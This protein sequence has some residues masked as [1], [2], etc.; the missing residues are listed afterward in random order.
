MER[1]HAL[2]CAFCFLTFDGF[3]ELAEHTQTAHVAPEDRIARDNVPEWAIPEEENN[4]MLPAPGTG[5]NASQR[6]SGG[7]RSNRKPPAVPFITV[8]DLTEEPKRA[9]ILGVQTQNTGFNDIIVKIAIGGRS[10]FLGLK[11]SNPNYELLFKAFGDNE[12]KWVGE[13]F[14]IGLNWNE[15]YEK[16]F[17]HVFDAPAKSAR[18][19]KE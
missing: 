6:E 11:A 14:T 19:G 12:N 15:F 17:V 2:E 3:K 5:K 8:E 13:E 10:Y 4:E 9:K 7:G 18:K 1:D 16:N